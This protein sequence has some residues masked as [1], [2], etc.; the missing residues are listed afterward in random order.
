MKK[1]DSSEL[2]TKLKNAIDELAER[3]KIVDKKFEKA[4]KL[5]E[6]MKEKDKK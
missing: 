4:T 5:L 6:K 1:T 3:Q 2:L